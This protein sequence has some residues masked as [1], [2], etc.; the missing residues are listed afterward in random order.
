[1]PSQPCHGPQRQHDTEK[2]KT[3][4]RHRPEG[5]LSLSAFRCSG[6]QREEALTLTK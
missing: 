6:E 1:M 2:H 4:Q 3:E 5:L